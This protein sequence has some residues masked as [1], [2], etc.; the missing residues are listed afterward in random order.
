MRNG[1]NYY[2][3]RLPITE[4]NQCTRFIIQ[5]FRWHFSGV[6]KDGL[7]IFCFT[8]NFEGRI[9]TVAPSIIY[10]STFPNVS[11]KKIYLHERATTYVHFSS[12]RY[13]AVL[14]SYC[15]FVETGNVLT[16]V[17]KFCCCSLVTSWP[18]TPLGVVM[19]MNFPSNLFV[20]LL[21]QKERVNFM[22]MSKKDVRRII[23]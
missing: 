11:K 20:V 14:F 18:Q 1:P 13:R 2:C 17:N 6:L 15:F 5:Y 19:E 22:C 4:K 7:L 16:W 12:R 23:F 8:Y 21:F 9:F 10:F 3:Y